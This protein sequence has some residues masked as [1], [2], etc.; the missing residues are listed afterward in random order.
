MAFFSAFLFHRLAKEP[1]FWVTHR[2]LFFF[3][4]PMKEIHSVPSQAGKS[5]TVEINRTLQGH[6]CLIQAEKV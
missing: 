1:V 3:S 2:V 5:R 6:Q 4:H